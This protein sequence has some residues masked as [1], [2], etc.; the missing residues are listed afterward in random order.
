[1]LIIIT[2]HFIVHIN[3]EIAIYFSHGSE[4]IATPISKVPRKTDIPL[5][6]LYLPLLS[7]VLYT[8]QMYLLPTWS[9]IFLV[10]T[11]QMIG[12]ESFRTLGN[13]SAN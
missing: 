12:I 6:I 8:G 11:N 2:V 5:H 13:C 3:R 9:C 7:A 4:L 10:G 1:M